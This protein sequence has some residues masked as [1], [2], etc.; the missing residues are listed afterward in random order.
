MNRPIPTQQNERMI[1]GTA[2]L[3]EMACEKLDTR[4]PTVATVAT[5]TAGMRISGGNVRSEVL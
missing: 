1:T 2:S 3:G 5:L 4:P